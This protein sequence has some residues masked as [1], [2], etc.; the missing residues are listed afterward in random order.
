[1]SSD[2]L[3][4]IKQFTEM[5]KFIAANN[6][7]EV[8]KLYLVAGTLIGVVVSGCISFLSSR[9]LFRKQTNRDAEILTNK[10]REEEKNLTRKLTS[11]L[12]GVHNEY[13][14]EY[15]VF[16]QNLI[17]SETYIRLAA[18]ENEKASNDLFTKLALSHN[19][20]LDESKT[21]LFKLLREISEIVGEYALLNEHSKVIEKY[22]LFIKSQPKPT[23]DFSKLVNFNDI[24]AL[25]AELI[26]KYNKILETDTDIKGMDVFKCMAAE[27][28]EKFKV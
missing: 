16:I 21:K 26:L 7:N 3:E 28:A 27:S 17:S 18:I 11:K 22:N 8:N 14:G 5:K 20:K 24:V 6:S 4:I 10:L 23:F 9:Y 25:R 15:Y 19:V 2:S 12:F 1:M 13:I